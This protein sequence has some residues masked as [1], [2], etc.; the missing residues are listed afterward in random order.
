MTL[1]KKSNVVWFMVML[2]AVAFSVAMMVAAPQKG[3]QLTYKTHEGEIL[4]YETVS[5][6]SRTM[7]REGETSE[8]KTTRTYNFQLQGE[9]SDAD[10]SFVLTINKVDMSSSGGRGGGFR[11]GVPEDIQGKRVRIKLAPDGKL[12][13]MTAIDEI[14][15]PEPR[16][17][18]QGDRPSDRRGDPLRLFRIKMLTLPDKSF[19]VG[20]SWTEKTKGAP[21]D[22]QGGFRFGG[23]EQTEERETKY[24]VL[25]QEMRNG[26]QCLHVSMTTKFNREGE[27]EM[28]GSEVS[29]EGEG[30]TTTEFWFAPQEGV[31][32]ELTESS[33]YE[34]TTA[35]SGDRNMTMPSSSE[36]K[37]T[38]K[39]VKYSPAAK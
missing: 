16:S 18:R 7:E 31:L 35:F 33:F 9:K 6:T 15:M 29:V 2:L 37:Y 39:L 30:E 12:G 38:L 26:L 11:G 21:E 24:T 19:E 32:V 13:E 22:D 28:R 5:E 14:K 34:G 23:I 27:G 10:L 1:F 36:S 8:F 17:G 20:K 25:G 3:G 4:V